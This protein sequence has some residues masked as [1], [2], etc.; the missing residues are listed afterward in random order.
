VV[1]AQLT[2]DIGADRRATRLVLR[3]NGRGATGALNQGTPAPTPRCVGVGARSDHVSMPH[4]RLLRSAAILLAGAVVALGVNACNQAATPTQN[5]ASTNA[6]SVEGAP[7]AVSDSA[8]PALPTYS[9]PPIPE[10]GYIWAPGYWAWNGDASDYYWVPGTWVQPPRAGLLWTPGYWAFFNGQYAFHQG[11]W[12]PHVGFYGGIDYGYG[13][14]GSGYQGGRWQSD[15]FYYNSAVNDLSGAPITHVYRQIVVDNR[16]SR[17]VSFNGAGG[18]VLARASSDE[19]AA[20][21]DAHVEPTAIQGQHVDLART[22]PGLRASMNGGRPAIAATSRPAV[23][24][25][26]GVITDAKTVTPYRPPA[27]SAKFAP[28]GQPAVEAGRSA[29]SRAATPPMSPELKPIQSA[30]AVRVITRPAQLGAQAR[31]A[32]HPAPPAPGPPAAVKSQPND[33]HD[34]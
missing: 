33:S 30:P 4:Q 11:Y 3:Q 13:Y 18:G 12:G 29:P 27:V 24:E 21:R 15:S 1:D 6:A 10:E 31:P 7:E 9:Q 5:A 32:E 23:F 22:N 16:A 17:H 26:K 28:E 19:L 20:A 34:H 2:F 8:P 25:G 14:S